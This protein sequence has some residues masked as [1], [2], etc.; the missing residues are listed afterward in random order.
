M[1]SFSRAAGSSTPR[2]SMTASRRRLHRR[3]GLGLRQGPQGRQGN[4]RRLRLHRHARPDRP[5]HPCLLGRHLARH[6]C[7]RV[8]PRLRRHHLGR[9]RLG[10]PRQLAGLPQARH[11]EEPGPHPRLSPRL[12]CR[13][14]R[15][16][17]PRHGRRERRSA[18][19]EPDRRVEVADKNRDLIVGI[20]VRVGLHASGNSGTV[21]LEHRAAGRQRGRH[22]ADVPYRPPAAIL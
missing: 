3:Q 13:H 5:A 2:R 14:L 8:L 22:A 9:H 21:P 6:R 19:D 12:A 18:H 10:R 11:R 17:P 7:R 16:R 4:P 20:K 15:L 1:I